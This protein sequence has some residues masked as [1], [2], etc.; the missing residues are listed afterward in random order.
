[1]T[2]P[3]HPGELLLN[4]RYELKQGSEMLPAGHVAAKQQFVL[5]EYYYEPIQLSAVPDLPA[6]EFGYGVA[7]SFSSA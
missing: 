7:I 6:P 3:E 1:M 2:Y 5:N 4:V